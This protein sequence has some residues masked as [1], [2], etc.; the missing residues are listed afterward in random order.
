MDNRNNMLQL[1]RL[2][3]VK[4]DVNIP[5]FEEHG[6][7][8]QIFLKISSCLPVKVSREDKLPKKI[9][10][11][12][13]FKLDT[14]YEFCNTSANAEKQLLTWL[15]EAGMNSQMVDGTIT[16]VTQ[17][18]KP[19]DTFVKEETIEP[20]DIH[21]E[22]DDDKDYMF[23][24]KFEESA[25]AGPSATVTSNEEEEPPPKR[26]RRT[27]AVKA[28]IALDH[29]SDDDDDDSGEPMTKV[30]DESEESEGEDQEPSFA[31]APSTSADDQPG[32]SGV[33]KDGVEAPFDLTEPLES[34]LI[35]KSRKI[36]CYTCLICFANFFSSTELI[37]HKTKHNGIFKENSL[38]SSRIEPESVEE[39]KD[40][41]DIS[42]IPD[43][44]KVETIVIDEEEDP[45]SP[46]IFPV[47]QLSDD[48]VTFTTVMD[49]ENTNDEE[50]RTMEEL[51]VTSS[52]ESCVEQPD[53]IS[54]NFS[55]DICYDILWSK[56]ELASHMAL[57]SEIKQ[58]D[59]SKESNERKNISEN[60][61][62]FR[63]SF[64][65][66]DVNR[67]SPQTVSIDNI[68]SFESNTTGMC[69][70]P[71]SIQSI[72]V[73]NLN[74]QD[75]L[76]EVPTNL[77]RVRYI[78]AEMTNHDI[79]SDADGNLFLLVVDSPA[80][81]NHQ[82]LVSSGSSKLHS[83]FSTSMLTPANFNVEQVMTKKFRPIKP[84][85]FRPIEPKNFESTRPK[86][87]R[88]KKDRTIGFQ[89]TEIR[90]VSLSREPS[91]RK[92]NIL[93][94]VLSHKK[95]NTKLRSVVPTIKSIDYNDFRDGQKQSSGSSINASHSVA[96]SEVSFFRS[97]HHKIQR[98]EEIVPHAP[99]KVP[100]VERILMPKITNVMSLDLEVMESDSIT[101]LDDDETEP[102]VPV[103]KP[104]DDDDDDIE[105]ELPM[106][107]I[108]RPN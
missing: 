5:I 63:K 102:H 1:C 96:E 82:S 68:Q 69:P 91:V 15:G 99:K 39:E 21:N 81:L 29:D 98:P 55:C 48:D 37:Q 10:D 94:K 2:C 75:E 59:I 62:S 73:H 93:R 7:I 8:R 12:C 44:T 64:T 35:N 25:S 26:A 43:D 33:G 31:D 83:E 52:P 84:K 24:Q 103:T 17:Q 97:Y 85:N 32:P 88:S 65:K 23:Q 28:A 80:S 16:A 105:R 57:H 61:V 79:V 107:L 76:N 53:I 6:D 95:G 60:T 78:E 87:V 36:A 71:S 92:P 56:D 11:G 4:D 106:S 45:V 49:T 108:I 27:A 13:S 14:L 54:N 38:S 40:P 22:D 104:V 70:D 9:C 50:E 19:T 41:L 30:E 47:E 20:P 67:S 58:M 46:D 74:S 3:L 86:V 66:V 101:V 77:N 72:V 100:T 90:E 18:I 34:S 51:L 89:R 42:G